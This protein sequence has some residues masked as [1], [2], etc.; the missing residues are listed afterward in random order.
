MIVSVVLCA[1]RP[2]LVCAGVNVL[3]ANPLGS[4]PILANATPKLLV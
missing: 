3:L 2:A 1:A 4:Y